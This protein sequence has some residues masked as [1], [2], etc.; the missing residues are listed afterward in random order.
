MLVPVILAGGKGERF[1]PAS[2]RARPKQFLAWMEGETLLRR[3]V[4]R[5]RA[6]APPEHT[7]VV[8]GEAYAPRVR[9]ELP[10]LPP[11]NV[12]AEPEG[13]NTA[14]SIGWAAVTL[15]ARFPGKE[16]ETVMAVLPADHAVGGEEAFCRDLLRAAAAARRYG[17]LVTFGVRPT[18]PETGYGYIE[19]APEPLEEGGLYAARQFREK[20]DRE[21]ASRF[22]ESG[23]FLWN[24]G[25]FVWTVEAILSAIRR[26]MPELAAGLQELAAAPEG[27]E[28]ART[29]A[30]VFPRLPATS[31][32]YGVLE[33]ATNVL[34]LPASFDWDDLGSW[35]ALDRVCPPDAQGN[36]ILARHLGEGT[37]GCVIVDIT[38]DGREGGGQHLVATLGVE[39]LVIVRTEDVTLV[40]PKERA[41]E[42]RVLLRRLSEQGLEAYL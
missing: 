17:A 42:I 32:D 10:E 37:R 33:R 1:W 24:S 3:T 41:Q 14:A 34:V 21:T 4:A 40:C 16:G 13:R 29:V 30:R 35:L 28:G 25:M 22:L 15:A 26:Y 31:I 39:E 7:L 5:V 23:R 8:T 19:V 20:P 38:R 6:V 2:R 27:P 9:A 36:V 18:R 11:D 12:L